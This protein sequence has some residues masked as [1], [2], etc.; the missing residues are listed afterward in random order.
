MSLARDSATG[1]D[2]SGKEEWAS[3]ERRKTVELRSQ[4]SHSGTRGGQGQE[5][6]LYRQYST[7]SS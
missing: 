3:S 4:R 2:R 1:V 5:G 7:D 6:A